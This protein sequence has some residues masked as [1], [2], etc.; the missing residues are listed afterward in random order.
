MALHLQLLLCTTT[1]HRT[2][3]TTDEPR[4]EVQGPNEKLQRPGIG[5]W[6]F[7]A[8]DCPASTITGQM[9]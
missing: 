9:G 7:H 3:Y 2:P 1:R 8:T 4:A 5:D 6:R